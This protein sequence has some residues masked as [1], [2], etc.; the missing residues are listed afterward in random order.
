MKKKYLQLSLVILIPF[1]FLIGSVPMDVVATPWLPD[2]FVNEPVA[3]NSGGQYLPIVASF[4][5]AEF[6]NQA[7]ADMYGSGWPYMQM[8]WTGNF[9]GSVTGPDADDDGVIQE[10]YIVAVVKN[11]W[12]P[13]PKYYSVPPPRTCRL[14][15]GF[16]TE[17]EPPDSFPLG[18]QFSVEGNYWREITYRVTNLET[19]W[20]PAMV[21]SHSLYAF[22]T[23]TDAANSLHSL[24]VDYVGIMYNWTAGP[25]DYEGTDFI[26]PGTAHLGPPSVI[27]TMG[28]FGFI[29]MIAIPPASLWFYRRD[30]G[31]KMAAIIT[32]LCAWLVCFGTFYAV[33][34]GG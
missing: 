21:K 27:G 13:P 17:T 30:G 4:H 16:G 22:I 9:S 6:V 19:D 28:L 1:A 23:S 10:V 33:I 12:V 18:E 26:P 8:V 20:T 7:W 3:H 31:S 2:N 24:Q 34:I 29:G 14:S 5:N 32:A 15:Y 11:G 25:T